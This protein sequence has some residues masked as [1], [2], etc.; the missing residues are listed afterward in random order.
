[1]FEIL[2]T[3]SPTRKGLVALAAEVARL[4]LEAEELGSDGR[5]LLGVKRGGVVSRTFTGDGLRTTSLS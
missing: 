5:H 3:P 4:A 2:R 1:V